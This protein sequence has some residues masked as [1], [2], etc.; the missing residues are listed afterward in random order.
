MTL[1]QFGQTIKQ[2]YPQYNDLPDIELGQKMLEKYPQ[3]S[4]MVEIPVPEQ[5]K[6]LIKIV[7]E[8]L[9]QRE[10]AIKTEFQ[11]GMAGE[12]SPARSAVRTIGQV[13]GGIGDIVGQ[14][15]IAAGKTVLPKFAE[16]AIA[17]GTQK[18][19]ESKPVQSLVK[20][21]SELEQ[22]YPEAGKDIRAIANI[23]SLMPITK[24]GQIAGK[25]ITQ[26]AIKAGEAGLKTV[27][28]T[29]RGIKGTAEFG[30]T[31][32][33]GLEPKTI[34]TIFKNPD[35]V[36]EA[37]KNSF[38]R[39]NAAEK[40]KEA[41]KTRIDELSATGKEYDIIKKTAGGVKLK[42]D[43]L[44]KVLSKFG[45]ISKDGKIVTTAESV[46]L[47]SGDVSELERFI[48]QYSP[49]QITSGNSFLNARKSLD[50]M[51]SWGADKTEFSEKISRALRRNYDEQGGNQIKGLKELDARYAPEVE[52]LNKLKKDFF[53]PQGELKDGAI[54]KIANLTGK[55][56][57]L[58][59]SRLK[60]IQPN[61]EQ[62]LQILKVIED[63]A[64]AKGQKVGT[65]IRGVIGGGS[66]LTGNII[67]I[68]ASILSSPHVAVPLIK[69]AGKLLEKGKNIRTELLKKLK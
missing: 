25:A 65:Y 20:G 4:D 54:N 5:P 44:N 48:G 12:I 39:L 40:V 52:L 69:R 21:F 17:A 38:T 34:S 47:S 55:G 23:V 31:Q 61:I 35:L 15:I 45:I 2:K 41:F 58:V 66:L 68:L 16:K 19:V 14:A 18:I 37:E 56:K 11:R 59:L 43:T 22:K 49:S 10:Q 64:I 36:S 32:I 13:A 53:T 60:K 29:G 27:K 30:I 6:R 51:S 28:A 57:E 33:T 26:T 62:E 63:I 9:S 67:G 50:Q 3:Y 7:G 1:E 8:D 42:D 24:G 46:P